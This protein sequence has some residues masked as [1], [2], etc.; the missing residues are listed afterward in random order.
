MQMGSHCMVS[1]NRLLCVRF[2]STSKEYTRDDQHDVLGQ[3]SHVEVLCVSAH[4][5]ACSS[6]FLEGSEAFIIQQTRL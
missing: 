6:V 5:L 3:S 4:V 1:W 2:D